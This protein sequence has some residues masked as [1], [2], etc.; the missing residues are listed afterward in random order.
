MAYKSWIRTTT[1]IDYIRL[2]SVLKIE[3]R[4]HIVSIELVS[5]R[6]ESFTDVDE[7]QGY[8][9]STGILNGLKTWLSNN[10]D[11]QVINTA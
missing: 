8:V 5:G 7:A 6:I 9:V 1:P 2:D 4:E 3:V 11:A 10:I